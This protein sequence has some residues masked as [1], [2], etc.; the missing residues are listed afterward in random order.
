MIKFLKKVRDY[1]RLATIFLIFI[2][3]IVLAS[4]MLPKEKKFRY[5]Y[6]IGSA[7][8]DDNLDSKF[9]F[10]IYKSEAELEAERDTIRKRVKPYFTFTGVENTGVLGNFEENF[11]KRWVA[12]SL[13]EF[14]IAEEQLYID[15]PRYSAYRNLQEE[16]QQ[17]L[18]S[19]FFNTYEN[20]IVQAPDE[21]ELVV[22]PE[23]AIKLLIGNVAVE[24]TYGELYSIRTA[25]QYIQDS[26]QAIVKT[27]ERGQIRSYLKFFNNLDINQYLS[28][29]V[30]FDKS[31][32]QR[33]KEQLEN[34]IS[35]T[36]D[37]IEEGTRLISKGQIVTPE[38]SKIL[39]SYKRE[40][41]QQ[42][43][44][45]NNFFVQVGR[46]LTIIILFVVVYLFL[47][48]FRRQVLDEI[49]KVVFILFMML[50]M[51]FAAYAASNSSFFDYNSFYIIP[52]AILPIVLRTFFD[53]RVALFVHIITVFIASFLA[54]NSF[55]FVFLS[56][57]AGMVALFSL[58]NLYKRS[59]FFLS[60]I[61]ITIT[62]SLA[63]VGLSVVQEGNF[64]NIELITFRYFA[65]NGVLILLSFLLI[66]LFEK[67]FGFLSDTTLLELADT[68]QP[69]L[70][71][72][73]EMAPATFQHSMQ[74]ANLSEEAVRHIG[75]NPMLVRTGA[76]YHDIGKMVDASYFTENQMGGT[77]PHAN[78][79]LKESAKII[80][81]HVEKG[82]DLAK[83]HNLPEPIIDFI[84]SHHGT[85]TTKYFLKTYQ[86]Q[87][88][89]EP[90]DEKDFQ[91][92]GPRPITKETAVLMMADSVEAASRSLPTYS[93]ESISELVE[94][95]I[96]SQM[97]EGQFENAAIT[98][99]DIK[100]VKEVFKARLNTIYHARIAYPK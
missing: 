16:Y 14:G 45:L 78:K 33:E 67:V 26:L 50:L 96:N 63:Y 64:S 74:V 73:A 41:E 32:T 94:R 75:G 79:D 40:Y 53:E 93:K 69:L 19:L 31:I 37:F 56:I 87:F 46:A 90:L 82:R 89:N 7:W 44:N 38:K 59:K 8:Y 98:F 1:F 68:N 22:H 13:V 81:D 27:D 2:V 61:L 83:K 72:L 12:Y 34:E 4:S 36:T 92:P 20:G 43:G 57:L 99:Q 100:K 5:E 24:I 49:K 6:H 21:E 66:Y 71:K 51:L 95:I 30:L 91:Y 77:N 55:E 52:F 85:S 58:T 25:Y 17:Q 39:D 3:A 62:Y 11:N 47:Y 10:S 29:N 15:E 9:S 35:L 18:Q 65:F 48:N 54:S 42:R 60:A 86:N 84:L 80:I 97:D 28:A 70:R 88:P 23:L 76:L